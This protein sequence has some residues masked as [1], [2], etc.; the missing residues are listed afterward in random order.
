MDKANINPEYVAQIRSLIG[1]WIKK[2]RLQKKLTQLELSKM[3]GVTE[4]TVS[5]MEA[6]KWL[7][8]EMLIKLSVNLEFYIFLLEKDSGDEL[9]VT[10][11]NRWQ[12]AHD[13]N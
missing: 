8:L 11:H 13:E 3:L 12:Q 6:G 5:K 4:A 7:S 9:A 1:S 2:F 10:M